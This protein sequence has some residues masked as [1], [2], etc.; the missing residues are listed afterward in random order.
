MRLEL[1]LG[2]RLGFRLGLRHHGDL[3]IIR[4]EIIVVCLADIT[5][6]RAYDGF[7]DF[8]FSVRAV[9]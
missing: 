4:G 3:L 8:L 6:D 9:I 5:Y 1:R 7:I 2:L